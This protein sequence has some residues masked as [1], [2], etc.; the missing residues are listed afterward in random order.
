VGDDPLAEGHLPNLRLARALLV[1][2]A[3]AVGAPSLD[4]TAHDLDALGTRHDAEDVGERRD[5]LP[6]LPGEV[7]KGVAVP[8]VD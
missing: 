7:M 4:T 8:R 6:G 2:A 5:Q 3:Q 1:P